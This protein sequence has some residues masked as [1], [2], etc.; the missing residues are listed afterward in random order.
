MTVED[1]AVWVIEEW[2]AEHASAVAAAAEQVQS[3]EAKG[4]SVDAAEVAAV[5][6]LLVALE[7]VVASHVD[8]SE[9][10]P[11]ALQSGDLSDHAAILEHAVDVLD[12]CRRPHLGSND[13][14]SKHVNAQRLRWRRSTTP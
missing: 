2:S 13:K 3:M 7:D 6:E 5:M 9:V 14:E 1:N 4:S 8:R 11:A 10:Q 12:T